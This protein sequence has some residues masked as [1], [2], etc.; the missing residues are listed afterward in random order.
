[1]VVFEIFFTIRGGL[2]IYLGKGNEPLTGTRRWKM[3]V[4][5]T[6]VEVAGYGW[7]DLEFVVGLGKKNFDLKC[8]LSNGFWVIKDECGNFTKEVENLRSLGLEI[9]G[10]DEH[11]DTLG[12]FILS[13]EG[14]KDNLEKIKRDRE[15]KAANQREDALKAQIAASDAYKGMKF[16]VSCGGTDVTFIDETDEATV[17]VV[18]ENGKWVSDETYTYWQGKYRQKMGDKLSR[19]DLFCDDMKN[20]IKRNLNRKA[21]KNEVQAGKDLLAK[22]L[23]ENKAALEGRGFSVPSS[24]EDKKVLSKKEGEGTIYLHLGWKDGQAMIMKQVVSIVTET[25]VGASTLL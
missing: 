9:E 24:Y 20:H 1:M 17:T 23:E 2:A 5:V 11:L 12:G 6:L 19:K 25:E 8:K 21:Q 10:L 4:A 15:Y 18:N 13:V 22:W 16:K 7:G 3:K 14:H